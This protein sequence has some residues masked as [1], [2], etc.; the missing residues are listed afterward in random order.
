V[1][2]RDFVPWLAELST[3]DLYWHLRNNGAVIHA[4]RRWI[5]SGD[6]SLYSI[7][8]TARHIQQVVQAQRYIVAELRRR[9]E[10]PDWKE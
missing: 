1:V 10:S 6:L 2:A 5:A 8:M 3:P 4:Q 9:G 7:D